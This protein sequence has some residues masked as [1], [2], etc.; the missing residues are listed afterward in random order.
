M[1]SQVKTYTFKFQKNTNIYLKNYERMIF[2]V[3]RKK[4]AKNRTIKVPINKKV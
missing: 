3:S 1:K 4:T 2:G